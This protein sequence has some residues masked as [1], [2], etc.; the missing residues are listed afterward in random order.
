MSKSQIKTRKKKIAF[1]LNGEKQEFYVDPTQKLLDFLR[2]QSL[3]SVKCGCRQG[4]CGMCTVLINGKPVKSC[5]YNA[6]F[7]NGKNLITLEGLNRNDGLHPIQQAFLETGAIQCGFCTP[8]QILST[9]A[10]LDKNSNPSKE[11]I[12]DALSGVLCR[13]TGYVRI[14]D[15]V[16]R[17]AA[18]LR[19][20]KKDP[21]RHIELTLPKNL[22]QLKIPREYYRRNDHKLPLPPIVLTPENMPKLN[23]VGQP[24]IKVDGE[25]LV[26]GRPVFTDDIHPEGMLYG[27][28]LTSPYAHALI[29]N[30]NTSK[31]RALDGVYAVLTHQDLPRVKYTSGGQSYPQPLPHDQVSL[32]NKVRH[33]GDKVA[34]VAAVTPEIAEEAMKL[35]DVDYEVLPH[36]IDAEEAMQDN[37]PIIHDEKDTEGIYDSIHNIVYHIEAEHGNPDSAFEEADHV[38]YGEFRTPKQQHA[39]LEPHVCSTYFDEDQRLVVRTSTQVPFHVRRIIAPLIGL[40]I[41][42]IRVIKPRIGGGFGGKQEIIL[43][44]LCAHLTI[45]TRQPV[46]M[47]YTRSQE[48]TSG[49]TRHR[50]IIRYKVGVKNNQV[51]VMELK[52]IG[53]TGAYGT[54]GLTVNMVGGFKGLTLYNPP[55]SR[56]ICN[57]V[58][59][60]TP[61]AGA[62][63]GYGAMQEQF[64]LEVIMEELADKLGVDVIKFKRQNWLKIGEPMHLARKL[65]EGREG[66]DQTMETSALDEC[67]QVGCEITDYYK[68]KK[69]YQSQTDQI[70]K[71]GI[72]MAVVFHG[73]GIAGLDMAA[74]TIKINDDGSFNLLIGATDIGTGSDTILAQIAAEE[75]GATIE[76]IIVYSSDTD[77]TPF[78]KG[79]YASS[80][81]YISGGAVQ[82]TARKVKQQ[83]L[84][85]AAKM[86]EVENI[87]ELII[88]NKKIIAPDK[89]SVTLQEVAL[90]S[91]HQMN[92]HQ[93]MATESHMSYVSPPPTAAQFAE[94]DVNTKTGEIKVV[95]LLT[96]VDC[97]RVIN[98]ITAAGQVEGGMSQ[99][100]GFVLSEDTLFNEKGKIINDR[101][102]S[103]HIPKI[104][105]TP[106]MDVVFI[107]TDEPSG[108]FGAKSVAEIAIDG[109]APAMVNAVHNATGVWLH[110]LP[111][112]PER[113]LKGLKSTSKSS[114]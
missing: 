78:D 104:T 12:L 26:R 67:V 59:T 47:E 74:A 29:K 39:Q 58:Y 4:D 57:V 61:P 6:T 13:C 21:F 5:L 103:Y 113:V 80:T 111:L 86:L 7:A 37:A 56:F 33:F 73:S 77:F 68:K 89:R 66:Y 101:F 106:P 64:A 84:E 18:Y 31:A 87:E 110:D 65:G 42:K 107:Q 44:D 30:I 40:P 108:P 49:R 88:R 93:I 99:G 10:L 20:E 75:L 36:V 38:I 53:D 28:L 50:Q 34:I 100:L 3:K 16:L 52:L 41:K 22:E 19:G 96:T 109:V 76:D 81:T 24:K 85:H 23:V 48:F 25:K 43:E 94:V 8:A 92:Q 11:E 112:T 14:I 63:R 114:L 17:A 83:I 90:S 55:N 9:K 102:S 105:E 62:F 35:I 98:P 95:R 2:E 54:H 46:R 70:I 51:T 60:N 45:V 97:G 82:K 71:H 91:L 15:A 32:D 27:T 69:A 72:G 1:T 79:A